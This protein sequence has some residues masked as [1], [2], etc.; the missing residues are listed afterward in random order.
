M[1]LIKIAV[2]ST[3]VLTLSC[4]V[5][6]V[7]DTTVVNQGAL[8]DK[9]LLDTIVV[10][11]NQINAIVENRSE[12]VIDSLTIMVDYAWLWHDEFNP[13]DDSP[14]WAEYVTF[15]R[16]LAP[17]EHAPFVYAPK[18]PL[19]ARDDGR[20]MPTAKIVG[21]TLFARPN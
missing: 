9:V 14:G 21:A 3:L 12:H 6:A 4:A 13:G 5:L 10:R 15:E 2:S 17:G 19:P 20:F 1:K 11:D 18:S 16:D 8:R 7:D